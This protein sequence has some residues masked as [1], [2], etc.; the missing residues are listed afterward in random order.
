[1]S[2][3]LENNHSSNS[4]NEQPTPKK[5]SLENLANFS[6]ILASVVSI[7]YDC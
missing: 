3:D 7:V 1:M 6:K 5:L 4:P 2:Q